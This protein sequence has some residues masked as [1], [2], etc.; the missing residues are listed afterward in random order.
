MIEIPPDALK[1]TALLMP[2]MMRRQ[3]SMR[4]RNARFVHYTS[5][6]VAVSILRNNNAWM[7][8]LVTMNDFSE[9]EHGKSCLFPAYKSDAGIK[10]KNF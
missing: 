8:N 4:R 6:E 10:L 7:R 1:F 3:S 9:V 2:H 5:A